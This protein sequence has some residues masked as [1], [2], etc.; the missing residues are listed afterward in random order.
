M[1]VGATGRWRRLFFGHPANACAEPRIMKRVGV[2]L[3]ARALAFVALVVGLTLTT[4]CAAE[5]LL[6]GGWPPRQDPGGGLQRLAEGNAN[7]GPASSVL[8]EVEHRLYQG[9]RLNDSDQQASAN[10][11]TNDQINK[12]RKKLN[13]EG[14][15]NKKVNENGVEIQVDKKKILITYDDC[16]KLDEQHVFEYCSKESIIETLRI[17]QD[18]MKEMEGYNPLKREVLRV[19]NFASISVGAGDL[20][21]QPLIPGSAFLLEPKHRLQYWNLNGWTIDTENKKIYHK[22]FKPSEKS[23]ALYAYVNNSEGA[24]KIL[25]PHNKSYLPPPPNKDVGN[26]IRRSVTSAYQAI[27][28]N[29]TTSTTKSSKASGDA[30]KSNSQTASV[31]KPV[32]DAKPINT[33]P[34]FDAIQIGNWNRIFITEPTTGICLGTVFAAE[35]NSQD[36][37]YYAYQGIDKQDLEKLQ[38]YDVS[39]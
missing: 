35:H 1:L 10:D 33:L 20:P 23:G 26:A 18:L 11:P 29:S 4:G 21:L 7:S 28:G 13:L 27:N 30:V 39:H 25:P 8:G 6:G 34:G 12:M 17:M 5:D 15:I 3:M 31:D 19:R 32:A 2:W 14:K 24:A 38:F 37:D 22:V 36:I 9:R 16:A